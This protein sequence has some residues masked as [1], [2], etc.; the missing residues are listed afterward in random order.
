M[1][2]ILCTRQPA[3]TTLH[4]PL[5]NTINVGMRQGDL[6]RICLIP[7]QAVSSVEDNMVDQ[8]PGLQWSLLDVQHALL[9]IAPI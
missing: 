3:G 4:V 5:V 7:S 6:E 8:L 1:S 2:S 9:K